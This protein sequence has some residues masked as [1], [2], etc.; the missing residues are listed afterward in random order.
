M[1]LQ[2]AAGERLIDEG[3]GAALVFLHHF[4]GSG[5][6]WAAVIDRLSYRFRC[7]APDLPGFGT[8][9]HSGP[10]TVAAS[11]QR[12]AALVERLGL[13]DYLFVGHSMGG[14]IALAVAAR[15]PPGLAGLVLLAPS[16]PTPEPIPEADRAHLLASWGNR[17]AM[18]ALVDRITVRPL[19]RSDRERQVADLLG[20]S[21][22]S[23]EAWLH[24]GSRE[25]IGA[26]LER[27]TVPMTIVSGD[28]DRNI[29][30]AVL[31]RE[32]LQRAP[33]A[34]MEMIAGAGHLLPVEARDEVAAIIERAHR[35][36]ALTGAD[37]IGNSGLFAG[38][39][40]S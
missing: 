36:P 17:E 5:S 29:T 7:I 25:D 27:I 37:P 9:R 20:T 22:A 16:P 40:R 33:T 10:C 26:S 4:G 38:N 23:W 19:S 18:V 12:V 8:A 14:K 31:R 15:R 39:L 34:S 6:G 28:G 24:S 21:R 13:A 32:L 30:A 11:A 2:P 1:A 35:E 3:R